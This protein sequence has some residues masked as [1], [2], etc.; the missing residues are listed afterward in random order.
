M[1]SPLLNSAGICF[2]A[3]A[4]C[5]TSPLANDSNGTTLTL[6][7]S[8][9]QKALPAEMAARGTGFFM[10]CAHG[11]GAAAREATLHQLPTS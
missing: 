2:E 8:Q 9:T 1:P 10:G 4:T 6:P 5:S 3:C 11:R 7:S